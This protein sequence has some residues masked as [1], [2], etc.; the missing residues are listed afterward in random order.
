V[1][2]TSD[3]PPGDVRA[4]HLPPGV[5]PATSGRAGVY[6]YFLG[7]AAYLPIDRA[8]AERLRAAMPPGGTVVYVDNDPRVAGHAGRLLSADGTAA[9]IT[10][11]VLHFAA[12]GG[13][14]R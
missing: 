3:L 5:D 12:P 8:V 10:A 9:V 14:S 11:G 2:E 1:I 7:G 13:R 4:A 6:G